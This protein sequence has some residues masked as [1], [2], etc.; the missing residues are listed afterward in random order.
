MGN[1]KAQYITL[2]AIWDGILQVMLP[3]AWRGYSGGQIY[4]YRY[5]LLLIK[6]IVQFWIQGGSCGNGELLLYN[7]A[8]CNEAKLP[9]AQDEK[10]EK[11]HPRINR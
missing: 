6:I 4:N 5:D 2:Q 1:A 7:V 11:P 8:D 10:G 3:G 9:N